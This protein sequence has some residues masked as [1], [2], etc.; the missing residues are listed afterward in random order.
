MYTFCSIGP[1]FEEAQVAPVE[2]G[3]LERPPEILGLIANHPAA[4]PD[5]AEAQKDQYDPTES[6]WVE[7]SDWER[8]SL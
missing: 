1:P 5:E 6:Q 7:P 3:I 2:S 8:H 4:C